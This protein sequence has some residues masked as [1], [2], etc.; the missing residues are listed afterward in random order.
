M[1]RSL[2]IILLLAVSLFSC[3]KLPESNDIPQP[4]DDEEIVEKTR[5]EVFAEL[6]GWKFRC[7]VYAEKQ[8]VADYGG[9]D[10][11]MRKVDQLL[12]DA[13][14]YF[15][16]KGINDEGGNQMHFFMTGFEV[17]EGASSKY[18]QDDDAVNETDYDLRIVINE[19]ALDSDAARGWYRSPH[20]SVGHSHKDGVFSPQARKQL[21]KYLA[22]SRGAYD[23]SQEEVLDGNNNWI[24]GARYVSPDCMTNDPDAIAH[25]SDFTKASINVSGDER[26]ATPYYELIPKGL[27]LTVKA[28]DGSI[29]KGV[30]LKFYPVQAGTGKV[31]RTPRYEGGLSVTGSYIFKDNPFFAMGQNYPTKNISNYLVDRK[32]VV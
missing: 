4:G 27:K 26:V 28:I 29:A 2:W 30:N 5:E 6:P 19:H 25:F 1:R 24:N 12:A 7:K 9:E 17:F 13:S 23:I 15:C 16:T 22:I 31:D 21:A 18:T 32:S 8:T 20:L 11:F 3:S 10:E 14:D